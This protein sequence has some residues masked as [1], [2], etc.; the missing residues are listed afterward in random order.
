VRVTIVPFDYPLEANPMH[1]EYDGIFLSNGPGDPQMCAST[2][3][4]VK[5]S[6]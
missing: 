5:V 2:V 6:T 3:A 1:I 4:S